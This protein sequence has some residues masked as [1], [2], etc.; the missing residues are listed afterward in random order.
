MLI[1][2]LFNPHNYIFL[3]KY[4]CVGVLLLNLVACGSSDD[5]LIGNWVSLY[6][7]DP[8]G[9]E[10]AV[11]VSVDDMGYFGTGYN[12][13]VDERYNDWW[14]VDASNG[15]VLNYIQLASFPGVARS[16]AVAFAINQDIYVGS[17]YDGDNL[18][19][20]FY[21]Y[22]IADDSWS[23]IDSLPDDAKPRKGAVAFTVNDKGYV[24]LGEAD[25]SVYLK[26]F[27]CYDPSTSKWTTSVSFG[28][29]KRKEAVSFVIDNVAYVVTGT[30]SANVN[31]FWKYDGNANPDN[32]VWENLRDISNTDDD[33]SYDD[34]Y[35]DIVRY[36]G[37]AFV[38]GDKGYVTTGRT[39]SGT[40]KVTWE[41][42]PSDDTWDEKTAFEG[43]S[44]VG[45]VSFSLNDVGYVLTGEYYS[46]IWRFE[47]DAEQN[48]YDNGST[49]Y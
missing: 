22:S 17:G 21:K 16:G 40:G 13:K 32:V 29:T 7:V 12:Y 5:D 15:D 26:D 41:Y 25:N 34:D 44:R 4:M 36:G 33:N 24:G 1:K 18:L 39:T 9:R 19:K 23:K 8:G 20:D 46:D 31:D 47:P 45:A 6:D 38:S 43:N 28:G 35:D 11:S 10:Y 3:L 30:K 14:K 42:D 27:Y 37:V 2:R 49:V 48:D